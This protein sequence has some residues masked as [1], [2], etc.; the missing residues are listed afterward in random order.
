MEVDLLPWE[1]GAADV[2]RNFHGSKLTPILVP[3]K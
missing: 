3:W 1:G 2:S